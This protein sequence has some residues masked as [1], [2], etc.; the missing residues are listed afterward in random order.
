M[1]TDIATRRDQIAALCRRHDVRR[2]ELFGSAAR[3][4]GFDPDR[5]DLDFLVEFSAD[6]PP[7]LAGFFALREGLADLLGRPVDLVAPAALRNP[8][9]RA[10][11]DRHREVVYAA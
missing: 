4:T 5:S 9:L 11:I 2:L 10:D 6:R 3:G 7:T 8:Y 1:L